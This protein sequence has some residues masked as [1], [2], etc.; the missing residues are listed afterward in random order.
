MGKEQHE[1]PWAGPRRPFS[2]RP[3]QSGHTQERA[4]LPASLGV[5]D[6]AG[7]APCGAGEGAG[8]SHSGRA[9]PGKWGSMA[10]SG[11][12][13]GEELLSFQAFQSRSPL[14][15][16]YGAR[17][18]WQRDF[19]RLR[20]SAARGGGRAGGPQLPSA[21]RSGGTGAAP[22]FSPGTCSASA[23]PPWQ[24]G[25]KGEETQCRGGS[26]AGVVGFPFSD[27]F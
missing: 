26:R 23:C 16:R 10:G 9:G 17:D 2:A 13:P 1:Q 6:G 4:R 5:P 18:S 27:P 3:P 24:Q 14:G 21:A 20:G 8:R 15:A 25:G 12:G 22:P 11:R 19:R 7:L